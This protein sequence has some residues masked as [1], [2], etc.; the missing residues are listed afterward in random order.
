MNYPFL[1]TLNLYIFNP[2]GSN[3]WYFLFFLKNLIILICVG[4]TFNFRS[5]AISKT[6]VINSWCSSSSSLSF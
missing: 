3:S 2:G 6:F 5:I 4:T 1:D